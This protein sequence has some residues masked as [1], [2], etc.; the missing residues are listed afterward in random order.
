[1]FFMFDALSIDFFRLKWLQQRDEEKRLNEMA[2]NTL[3]SH[4]FE[5][6]DKMYSEEVNVHSTEEE[7]SS[8][9]DG[10]RVTQEWLE[11]DGYEAATEVY[12]Q[13]Y[14]ELK[15]LSRPVFRRLKEALKRPKLLQELIVSL[16]GSYGM[17]LYMRN[18]TES[19]FTEVEIKTLEDLTMET[20]VTNPIIYL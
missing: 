12:Q 15:R 6:Q 20:L 11:D 14:R 5:T 17:I 2:K 3:E 19:V 10:L 9:L 4:I 1:M 8:I 7:R 18:M 16:N 13:K